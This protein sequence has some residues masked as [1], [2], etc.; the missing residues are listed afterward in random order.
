MMSDT[1]IEECSRA[2]SKNIVRVPKRS[3]QRDGHKSS[4]SLEEP[5]WDALQEI[6]QRN[7]T[8]VSQLVAAIDHGD[9]RNN[10]SSAI[11]VFIIKY[12]IDAGRS[13]QSTWASNRLTGVI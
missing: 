7:N 12:Y 2:D 11:R 1:S 10:L 3:I 9:N 8:S 6:A 4:V 13:L 5:F